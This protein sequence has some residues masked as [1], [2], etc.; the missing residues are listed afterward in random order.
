MY[1]RGHTPDTDAT[2]L[3]FDPG[4]SQLTRRSRVEMWKFVSAG[5]SDGHSLLHSLNVNQGRQ[6]WEYDAA[7]GTAEQR[8]QVEQL[9]AKFAASRHTQKHSSDE[10]LR[11]Q[12]R[13][14]IAGKQHSPP[15]KPLGEDEQVG[16][17]CC[18]LSCWSH[19]APALGR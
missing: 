19:A 10:L 18:G 5:N 14:K 3:A 16:A 2:D 4:S 17:S 1:T 6:T 7:A 12:C 15:G 13:D 8:K 9:R 11:L